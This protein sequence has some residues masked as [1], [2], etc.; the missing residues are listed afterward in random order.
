[1]K[2]D[3]RVLLAFIAHELNN[4]LNVVLGHLQQLAKEAPETDREPILAAHRNARRIAELGR[5]LQ[6]VAQ[7]TTHDDVVAR[8]T[9]LLPAR[10]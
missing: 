3:I 6:T 4:P 10:D 1:M 5:A 9:A 7:E 2:V 8:I